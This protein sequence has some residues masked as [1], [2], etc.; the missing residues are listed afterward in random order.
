MDIFRDI[1]SLKK[2]LYQAKL[3]GKSIGLVPTMGALHLGHATLIKA[4]IEENEVSVCSIFVN[5][6][7]FNNSNDL[8]VY[9]R[10]LENDTKLLE[11]LG[12]DILFCP[13]VEEIYKEKAVLNFDF[14]HLENVMEGAFRPKHFNGVALIVSKLFHIVDPERAYFG[15]KDLQ[16]FKVVSQLVQDLSF[17]IELKCIPIVREDDGLAMSSRNVR[18]SKE[19]RIK[20]AS[21]NKMLVKGESLLKQ[22]KLFSDIKDSLLDDLHSQGMEVE[23]CELVETNALN[24]INAI[25]RHQ[26]SA[27]CVAVVVEG[28]RLIDNRIF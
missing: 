5:P 26:L 18:L 14:G 9:P 2:R 10:T 1:S 27:I 16:Q 25:S 8:S 21:I 11:T 22:G 12:C 23:Y 24:K 15:Q 3:E 17:N 4:A 7:Q 28:V 13:E 19:G 20:A 6:T